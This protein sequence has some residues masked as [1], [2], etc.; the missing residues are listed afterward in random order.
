MPGLAVLDALRR[1]LDA[2]AGQPGDGALPRLHALWVGSERIESELVPAYGV[3]FRQLD[4]RFSY[5][6]LTPGNWSYYRKHILPIFLGRPFR[7]ALAVVDGFQPHMVLGTGGYVSAPAIWAAQ[8][9]GIPYALLQ[10]DYPPGVV[11]WHFADDAARVYAACPRVAEALAG[12]CAARKVQVAGFPALLPRMTRGEFFEQH[13]LDQAKRLLIVMGGSLGA[14]AIRDAAGELL[15]AAAVSA[16][17]RWQELCVLDIGGSRAQADE[18]A[19][20]SLRQA[21]IELKRTGY[22]KCAVNAVYAADFYIGRSGAATVGELLAAGI[23]SLLIPDPQHADKQQY[24][25]AQALVQHGVGTIVEQRDVAGA[26]LLAWLKR[27]WDAPRRPAPAMAAEVIAADI[28]ERW[29]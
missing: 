4:I 7:Q 23:P 2:A 5:R 1:I 9:R 10:C 24:W 14:G 12:R 19:G 15:A 11:N 27:A 22:L 6:R 21:G 20:R 18:P 3:A 29:G 16:D 28:L 8:H 13:G 17:T 25:N 26:A